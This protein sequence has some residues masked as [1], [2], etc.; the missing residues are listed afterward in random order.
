MKWKILPVPEVADDYDGHFHAIRLNSLGSLYW[1]TKYTLGKN[2]LTTLHKYLAKSLETEDLFLVMEVPMS[3]FKTTLGIGFSIFSALPF[4]ERDEEAMR[5]LGYGDAWIR[6]MKFAHDQNMRTLVTHEIAEQAAAIGKGVDEAYEN[7]DVFR[8]VF[9]EII[10]DRDC[11]WTNAHK[12]QKRLPGADPTTGTF[13]YRGVGQALQGI[14]V[15][16]IIQDDNFGREAQRS[17]LKGDGRIVRDLIGWHKQVGTRF[18]PMVKESR[19]QLVI[20]NAW[21]HAD[22]NAWIK[23]HQP[24]F[25]F[26]SHS[27]EGGCCKRHPAG[28]PILPTEWTLELLH[29]EKARLEAGGDSGGEKGDYEHFYLNLHTL[30]WETVFD[31]KTLNYFKFKQSRPDLKMEDLRNILLLQHEVR[32]GN[33]IDD[34]QPGGLIIRML[35]DPNHAKKVNRIEHVIWVIGYDME[36]T[37][38]YLLS[39]WSDNCKY[40]A[41]LEEIYR[42]ARRWHLENYWMGELAAELL[43]FYMK[44]R[45]RIEPESSRLSVNTFPDD[46]S[47][48][49]MKNRIEALEPVLRGGQVWAHRGSQEKF[50]SQ[51]EMYPAGAVDTLDVLGNFTSTIDVVHGADKF[52]Q[53]QQSAFRNRSSGAGGY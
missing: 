24:E 5:K 30:P 4:T 9:R 33:V 17:L 11:T 32:D 3:H 26:E 43:D 28:K 34:F 6:W 47:Q 18:D 10:P 37:R 27:A 31:I 16:L 35:V 1:F 53:E 38:I 12:F 42:T 22:L 49:G 44:Q 20:G 25:K 8:N 15:K 45:D 19:R 51:L 50:T 21:A 14:H 39:L 46:D 7:N 13:E 36:T 41:L 23:K 2:R 48:M 40:S 29:K 52:L